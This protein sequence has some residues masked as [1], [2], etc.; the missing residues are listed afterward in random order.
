MKIGHFRQKFKKLF[1]EF[2]RKNQTLEIYI[3]QKILTII[4]EHFKKS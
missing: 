1:V 3:I 4:C 2:Y